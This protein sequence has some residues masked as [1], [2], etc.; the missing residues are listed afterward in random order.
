MY[1]VL[2]VEVPK[3]LGDFGKL[4]KTEFQLDGCNSIRPTYRQVLTVLGPPD[5]VRCVMCVKM[6][7][8][9]IHGETMESLGEKIS[10]STP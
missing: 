10:K 9:F 3:T 2:R 1:N 6:V 5:C 8:C 4:M 7:P